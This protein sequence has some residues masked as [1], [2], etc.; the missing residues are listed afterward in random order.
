VFVP[1]GLVVREFFIVRLLTALVG[2][3]AP[4]AAAAALLS[5]AWSMLG[6]VLWAAMAS[7]L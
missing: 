4:I 7:R 5:R 1:Q 3:P 6:I 2:V